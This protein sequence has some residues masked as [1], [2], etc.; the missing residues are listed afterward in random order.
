VSRNGNRLVVRS[1]HHESRGADQ[2]GHGRSDRTA[3][4]DKRVEPGAGERQRFPR[5]SCR[6]GRETPKITEVLPLLLHDLSLGT[7]CL[8]SESF[9]GSAKGLSGPV[10]TKLIERWKVEQRVLRA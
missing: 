2:C 4:N 7:S 1:G 3:G 5:R 6:R 9:L 8:H 10:I